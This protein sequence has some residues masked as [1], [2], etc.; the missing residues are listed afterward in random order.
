MNKNVYYDEF[1]NIKQQADSGDHAKAVAMIMAAYDDKPMADIMN[2]LSAQ[3]D[4]YDDNDTDGAINRTYTAIDTMIKDRQTRHAERY[5]D[6]LTDDMIRHMSSGEVTAD[7]YSYIHSQYNE[8]GLFDP[9]IFGGSGDIQVCQTEADLDFH[10][11]GTKMGHIELP[12]HVVLKSHYGIIGQLL[13]LKSEDVSKIVN[14]AY[15]VNK[16]DYHLATEKEFRDCGGNMSEWMTGGDAIYEM[17]LELNYEDKPE[18]LAFQVVSVISPV[19]RPMAYLES[20]NIYLMVHINTIYENIL[21]RLARLQKLE[22]LGAP[23]VIVMNEKR[24]LNKHVNALAECAQKG[25]RDLTSRFAKTKGNTKIQHD[26]CQ[27]LMICRR[28]ILHFYQLPE[29]P[30]TKI[31][32]LH[33]FP[34]QILV[35]QDDGTTQAIDLEYV[36]DTNT[37]ALCEFDEKHIMIFPDNVDIENLP[38]DLQVESDAIDEEHNRL[39]AMANAIWDMAKEKQELCKVAF[40]KETGMYH[41]A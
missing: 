35:E 18:R 30:A 40:D 3:L 31:Q 7:S 4:F 19:S 23:D 11:F 29:V 16:S 20:E 13:H 22:S 27:F 9:A 34:K 39:E 26:Y 28:N 32:S 25:V 2:Q 36:I 21:N 8:H 38:A 37:D 17:L 24:M 6:K 14:F 41:I 33:M 5:V 15:Y 1:E 10:T 12:C